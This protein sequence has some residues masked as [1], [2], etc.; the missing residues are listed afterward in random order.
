MDMCYRRWID[1]AE[2][3]VVTG[4]LIV[5]LG[6][7]LSAGIHMARERVV[8]RAAAQLAAVAGACEDLYREYH[9]WPMALQETGGDLQY[10]ARMPN[11]LIV[12]VL[13]ARDGPGNVGHQANPARI[14]F[15]RKIPAFR[16]GYGGLD[17]TGDLLDPWGRPVRVVLDT[18]EDGFCR[19]ESGEIEPVAD[20][21]A[22]AWSGGRDGVFGTPDDVRSWEILRARR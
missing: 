6:T 11:R 1:I 12:N 14:V 20:V 7:G 17:E 13:L 19:A 16:P 8:E 21:N 10:G 5:L 22:A 2:L 15:L 4:I 3:G 9:G 18:D